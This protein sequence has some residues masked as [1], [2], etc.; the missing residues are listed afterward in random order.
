MSQIEDLEKKITIAISKISKGKAT[1]AE[2]GAGVLFKY[3]KP[4]DEP[5]YDK[6]M[7]EYKIALST[8]KKN[9]P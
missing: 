9:N 3:L 5:L 4:L 7:S 8:Y 1:P 6:L 2:S